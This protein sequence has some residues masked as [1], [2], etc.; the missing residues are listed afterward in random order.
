MSDQR[1]SYEHALADIGAESGKG[2]LKVYV[3]YE[4]DANGEWTIRARNVP[5]LGPMTARELALLCV[6]L[7]DS[8][9]QLV[10]K[11]ADAVPDAYQIKRGVFL[12]GIYLE[13]NRQNIGHPDKMMES[14]DAIGPVEPRKR[15]D[16]NGRDADPVA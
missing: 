4:K 6:A 1:T 11:L 16:T 15:D 12:K 14:R 5:H 2:F 9:N 7:L 13:S 3:W 8:S 10:Q